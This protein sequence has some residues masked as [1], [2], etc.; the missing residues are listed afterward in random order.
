VMQEDTRLNV[1]QMV[2]IIHNQLRISS[3]FLFGERK[4]RLTNLLA[5]CLRRSLNALVSTFIQ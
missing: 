2:P 3:V 1:G 5:Q 4:V